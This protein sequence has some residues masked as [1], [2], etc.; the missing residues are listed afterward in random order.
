MSLERDRSKK[1]SENKFLK[2]SEIRD[3]LEVPSAAFEKSKNPVMN[4]RRM[5]VEER[6]VLQSLDKLNNTS[7]F[8]KEDHR[9][10]EQNELE[11]TKSE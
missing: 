6:K 4:A 9:H 7:S 11:K 1:Y 3:R 8:Q 2:R 10:Q 5:S